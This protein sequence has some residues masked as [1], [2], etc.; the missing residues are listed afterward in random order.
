MR[1]PTTSSRPRTVLLGARPA[2][3][4]ALVVVIWV[5]G[6][7]LLMGTAMTVGVR[8]RT[9]TD[10]SLF[11][12]QRAEIAAESAINLAILLQLSKNGR[13][14]TPF[15]LTCRMPSGEQVTISVSEEAGKV[16][17]NTASSGTLVNLFVGLTKNR[18]TGERIAA[19]VLSNRPSATSGQSATSPSKPH[20]FQSVMELES[21]EGVTSELFQAALPLVTVRSGK[22]EPDLAAAPD[23]LRD[24]LG[25]QKSATSGATAPHGTNGEITVRADASASANARFIREALVSLR[26]ERDRPFSIREWRHG[27]AGEPF[28]RGASKDLQPCLATVPTER[29]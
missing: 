10:S 13:E 8:Y 19:A 2:G 29:H 5:L 20:V 14:K 15:P 25:L 16:D 7:V 4:Y 21:V 22:V 11:D 12:S 23:A 24:A 18:A 1:M 26:Q 6:L 27:D 28:L 17:L 3:G 9:R